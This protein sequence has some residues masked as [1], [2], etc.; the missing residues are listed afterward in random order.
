MIDF[1][2]QIKSLS[3]EIN[4]IKARNRRVE[5]DKAWETSKTRSIFIALST[6]LLIYIFMRLIGD[7][8][9]FLNALVASTGYLISTFTYDVLK[10]WWLAKRKPQ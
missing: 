3:E 6:Y 7:D 5:G 9:P 2:S 1:N 4:K 10:K 8:H